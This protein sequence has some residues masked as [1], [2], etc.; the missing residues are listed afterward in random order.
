[1]VL[2]QEPPGPAIVRIARER[3]DALA[4]LLPAQRRVAELEE[5]LAAHVQQA[6]PPEP[7][8]RERARSLLTDCPLKCSADH[9][10]SPLILNA[11]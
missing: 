5:D 4:A 11:H 2:K 10:P 8:E 9:S 7:R 3:N 6:S 1:M